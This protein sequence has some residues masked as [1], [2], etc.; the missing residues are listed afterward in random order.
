MPHFHVALALLLGLGLLAAGSPAAAEISVAQAEYADDT[1]ILR[2]RT[3]RPNTRVTL[4]DRYATRSAP[5]GK[6]SFQ[7]GYQP[8]DCSVDLRTRHATRTVVI[9]NCA[10][11]EPDEKTP[12]VHEFGSGRP[13]PL[14]R[15]PRIVDP[16]M[17]DPGHAFQDVPFSLDADRED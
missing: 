17:G 14:F 9:A 7:I 1:L 4:D 2:G 5:N 6:F 11:G 16:T 13:D 3:E 8:A 12:L 10:W 15:T